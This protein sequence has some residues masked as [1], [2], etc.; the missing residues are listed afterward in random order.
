MKIRPGFF[1]NLFKI[2]Q[3][4]FQYKIVLVLLAI[5]SVYGCKRK[6][7]KLPNTAPDTIITPEKINL[8][9]DDRLNS[10]VFLSWYGTDKDGYVSEYEISLD[11][12][13]W[14]K[15]TQNDS[16]FSFTLNEGSDTTDISFYVRAID[17]EGFTDPT[18][19][20]L[21][22]PLKNTPPVVSFSENGFPQDSAHIVTTFTWAA[23]DVDGDETIVKAYLKANQGDWV[24]IS[25]NE[26]MIS[27]VPTN[28][29]QTGIT[30]AYIYYGTNQVPLS[31]TLN[32]VNVGDT[33]TF[34]LKVIDFAEAESAPDTSETLFIK[35]KISSRLFVSGLPSGA[36]T[37]YKTAL[38][39]SN[40]DNDFLDYSSD[41]GKF[42]PRFWSPTF[43]LLVNNYEDIIVV[44]DV[45]IFTNA[46]TGRKSGLLDFMAPSLQSFSN[47]GGK[48][49]VVTSFIKG[50]DIS[51][52]TG[53]FPI[54]SL[55]SSVGQA[56][57]YPDS[58]ITSILGVGYPDMGAINVL[59]G[60]SPFYL[61]IDAEEAY[62]GHFTPVQGWQGPTTVGARRKNGNN[63]YYQYFF[64][65]QLYQLDQS[66]SDLQTLFDQILNN[67]FNW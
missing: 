57:L 25:V 35:P 21:N 45:T 13:N 54:D 1:I 4:K 53:I 2:Y 29:S 32:G 64:S 49:L 16:V 6:H 26:T 8:A 62:E 48:S 30:D 66:P 18:P 22:V 11:N 33:N 46:V 56:R 28:V 17:N 34:Y 44:S 20:Y 14:A 51:G 47:N 19:A 12:Q 65:V 10:I 31:T 41:G 50:Q 39:A 63:K 42:Q 61:S 40:I 27:L 36:T 9:G 67:D 58:S 43:D 55:S 5:L 52:I 3:M 59:S 24:E 60:Q 23:S 37:I 38:S 7:D 15:T